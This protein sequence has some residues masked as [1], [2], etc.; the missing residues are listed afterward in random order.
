VFERLHYQVLTL[1]I[2]SFVIKIL[3]GKEEEREEEWREGSLHCSFLTS[4]WK[5]PQVA[6]VS[7]GRNN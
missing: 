3:M 4:C 5:Q 7:P 1:V 6:T 2:F